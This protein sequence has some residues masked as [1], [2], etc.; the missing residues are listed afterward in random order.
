MEENQS[1]KI[2]KPAEGKKKDL[3]LPIAIVLAALIIGGAMV[4][5][6]GLSTIESADSA[7]NTQ[8]SN[9]VKLEIASDQVFLGKADAPITIFEFGDY[10]CP[11]CRRFHML[12]HL[13]LVKDYVDS[14]L[15]KVVFMDF[16][17]PGH[18]FAQ[19]ASEAAWC[20]KDQNKFWEM[21]DALFEN[22]GTTNGLTIDNIIKYAG[23]LGMD[24]QI[25]EQCL[26]SSKY[27]ARVQ[28][29]LEMS[30]RL[31]IQATPTTIITNKPLP[32]VLDAKAVVAAYQSSN[33]GIANLGDS[34]LIIGAQPYSTIKSVIDSLVK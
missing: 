27:A 4:Y 23:N 16:P 34:F 1:E 2:K 24:T 14:G 21:H 11:Y 26:N 19:K 5:S 10:Q 17:L 13:D 28:Q 31:G 6:K 12:A 32:L 3:V 8:N 15:A 7:L 30:A 25:F 18:E 9:G 33:G 22:S 29:I 20:A